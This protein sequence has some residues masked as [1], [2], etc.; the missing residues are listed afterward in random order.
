ML[1]PQSNEGVRLPDIETGAE[2]FEDLHFA[3]Q[4]RLLVLV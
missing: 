4:L 2:G 3:S 1:Y